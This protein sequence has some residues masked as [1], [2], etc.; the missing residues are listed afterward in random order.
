[1]EAELFYGDG[2]TDRNDEANIRFSQLCERA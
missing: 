1:M 2:R